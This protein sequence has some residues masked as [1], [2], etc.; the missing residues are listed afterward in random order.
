MDTNKLLTLLLDLAVFALG[1]ESSLVRVLA[2][3]ILVGDG[4]GAIA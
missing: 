1:A 2:D 3:W 4:Q